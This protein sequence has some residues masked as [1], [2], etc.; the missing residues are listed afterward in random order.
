M[1]DISRAMFS[2]LVLAEGQLSAFDYI[3]LKLEASFVLHG[4]C[5]PASRAPSQ[6]A[7]AD[8]ARRR[9]EAAAELSLPL[10]P[11]MFVV[12]LREDKQVP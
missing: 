6:A 11:P 5:R 12:V 4:H 2:L 7:A 8:S 10:P 3:E 1:P 9:V